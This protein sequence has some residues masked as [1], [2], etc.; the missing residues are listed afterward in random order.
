MPVGRVAWVMDKPEENVVS[1]K[2]LEHPSKNTSY[3]DE[4]IERLIIE[5]RK[6]ENDYTLPILTEIADYISES[7]DHPF[8]DQCFYKLEECI[9]WYER[10]SEL[11]DEQ[12]KD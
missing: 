3:I 11:Q 7:E 9:M 6:S 12:D 2:L 8:L 5:I 1:L 10:W 4:R